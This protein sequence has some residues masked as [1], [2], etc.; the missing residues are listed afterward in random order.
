MSDIPNTEAPI[1]ALITVCHEIAKEAVKRDEAFI[2][3]VNANERADIL[4]RVFVKAYK[5]IV[6]KEAM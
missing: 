5:A 4:I 1:V 3:S 6:S 2:D